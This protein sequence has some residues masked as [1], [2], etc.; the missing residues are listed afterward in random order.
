M[1]DSLIGFV[2]LDYVLLIAD[3]AQAR[4][5][6]TLKH[7]EDKIFSL[8]SHKLIAHAGPAGDRDNFAHYIQKNLSLYK[9]RTGTPL[10]TEAAANFTRHELSTALRRDPYQVN[11]LLGGFDEKEGASMY[12]LDYLGSMH[13][14]PFGAHGMAS[15]FVLGLFDRYYKEGLSLEDGIKLADLAIAEVQK[16]FLI[17]QPTFIIKVITKDGIKVLRDAPPAFSVPAK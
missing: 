10:N 8:D 5:I 12:Y 17:S 11:L 7:N 6:L 16:R 4:G 13:K 15:K 14:M 9:Y 2:G 3:T 1:S